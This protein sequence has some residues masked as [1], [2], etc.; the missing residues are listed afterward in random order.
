MDKNALTKGFLQYVILAFF[1]YFNVSAWNSTVF[2]WFV[3]ALFLLLSAGGI[4]RAL[5]NFFGLSKHWR[6]KIISVFIAWSF[7]GCVS[8]LMNLVFGVNPLTS[9]VSLFFCGSACLLIGCWAK[10][11]EEDTPQLDNENFS[12]LE[13]EPVLKIAVILF[14]L[15][16]IL[17]FFFLATSQTGIVLETP[18]QAIGPKYIITF[19]LSTLL[20]GYLI[21]S[22]VRIKVALFFL[23][24]HSLL[25]HGYLP[26]THAFIYGAD[27]WRHMAVEQSMIEEGFERIAEVNGA[28]P[29]FDVGRLAYAQFH[30]QA[31]FAN[32]MLQIDLMQYMKWSTPIVW[33]I[34]FVLII[35]ELAIALGAEKRHALFAVWIL[36][37]PF[38]LQA[39]GS[40]T[41]PSNTAFL[42]FLCAL[43]MILKY[44]QNRS[45]NALYFLLLVGASMILMHTLFFILFWISFLAVWFVKGKRYLIEPILLA[46][47]IPFLELLFGY[48]QFKSFNILSAIKSFVANLSGY[49]LASGPRPHDVPIGNIF[50][51]QTPSYAFVE[52]VFVAVR[53]PVVVF[54]FGFAVVCLFALKKYINGKKN[55]Q[56][57]F[58]LLAVSLPFSYFISRY[59]LGGENILARRLDS[60]L[61]VLLAL[62]VAIFV[63]EKICSVTSRSSYWKIAPY[64][65]ICILSFAISISYSLGPDSRVVSDGEYSASKLVYSLQDGGACVVGDTFSLLPLE[66]LSS[67]RIIGGGFPI[68]AN[69]AQ[70]ER[71]KF[72]DLVKVGDK[73]I[74]WNEAKEIT[75][76]EVCYL[77]GDFNYPNPIAQFGNVKVFKF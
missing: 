44:A 76:A 8:G 9:A 33:S 36:L 29:I 74:N 25:L 58:A 2:G 57:I 14:V 22:G 32:Q 68:T 24:V 7:F 15:S 30:A 61:A 45:K 17:G 63:S 21:F 50:F 3:F 16:E 4:R 20:L 40:F 71:E 66:F 69:F 72:L 70:G 38:A 75:G 52:N 1:A 10:E 19:F 73:N 35:F 47:T 65:V 23:I 42:F 53:W 56:I 62:P 12:V 64:L 28:T 31:I 46:C 51:N 18:W 13:E 39:S 26:L 49:Y 43:L 67:K 55:A 6:I 48:S 37:L 60:T 5:V 41:L 59:L 11:V 27:G 77:I 54:M 34:I